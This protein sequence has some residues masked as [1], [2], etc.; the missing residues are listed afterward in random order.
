MNSCITCNKPLEQE[1][2][3]LKF[4]LLEIAF[5]EDCSMGEEA[6]KILAGLVER[7]RRSVVAA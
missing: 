2:V 3:I 6:T 1:R 7:K 4:A 5:C